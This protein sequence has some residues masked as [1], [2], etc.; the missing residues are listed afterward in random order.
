MRLIAMIPAR[1]GSKRIPRK[2]LRLLGNKPLVAWATETARDSGLFDE[3]YINSEA[4]ELEQL[5]AQLSVS[6]YRRDPALAIDTASSDQFTADFLRNVDCDALFQIT[7]TSPFLTR[8]DLE[9]AITEFNKPGID[10]LV[11][12]RELRTECL[13]HRH[14]PINFNP[15][16]TM[17]PSQDL[18]PVYVYCNGVFGW[19]R[20]TFLARYD[21]HGS[22]TY[23]PPLQA[24][25][26]VL[27]GNST[28]DLDTEDDWKVAEAIV[29]SRREPVAKPRYWTPTLRQETD[30]IGCAQRDGVGYAVR[31]IK[32]DGWSVTFLNRSIKPS[33]GV[34]MPNSASLWRVVETSSS[35]AT[36]ISQMP[37]EGNRRHYHPDC[38]EWWLILEGEFD[39]TVDDRTQRVVEGD[40]VVVPRGIWHQITAVGSQRAVRLAVSEE[41]AAH[42]YS[43]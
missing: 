8:A 28:L 13:N 15:L 31:Y 19:H 20:D 22:A 39:F 21:Q 16:A 9:R 14:D 43:D 23:P 7:P 42:V 2:N 30:S 3:V 6:F 26:L 32:H 34:L 37:G 41:G 4:N 1:L 33:A 11:S 10:T 35:V 24:G 27:S 40:L 18:P 5:A 36:V 12:V 17:L 29:A 38:D 25:Y